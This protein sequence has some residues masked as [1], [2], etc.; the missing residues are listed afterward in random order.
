MKG[1]ALTQQSKTLNSKLHSQILEFCK[2]I[3]GSNKIKAVYACKSYSLGNTNGMAPLE[4]F[5]VI[6]AFQPKLVN[7]VKTFCERNVIFFAVDQWVFE[8]D[9]DKGFLGEAL[10]ASLLLPYIAST[11]E[12]YLFSQE[13]KLKKRLVKELLEN[14]VTD[15]PELSHEIHI[16]PEYFMYEIL[17]S[18][19]RIFPPLIYTL[20]NFDLKNKE[21][22]QAILNGYLKAL[23]ELEKEKIIELS[24]GYVKISRDFIATFR[25]QKIRFTSLFKTAQRTLFVSM[26]KIFPRIISFLSESKDFPLMIQKALA[27]NSGITSQIE[28]PKK[29]LLV[30]TANGLVPLASRVD[31]EAFAKKTLRVDKNAKIVFEEIGGVLNDVYLIKIFVKGEERK[32]VVKSFRDLSSFKW[33]PLTLWTLGTRSFAVSGQSRL[34]REYAINQFLSSKGFAVPKIVHV[35]TAKRLIFMEYVEGENLE[36]IVKRIA[37]SKNIQETAKDLDVI[38]RVGE[39]F[40]EIH[41]LGVALGDTKPENIMVAQNG[42]IY[43]LDFEQASRNG[44]K[45]WDVAEFLYY[46]GHHI[47]PLASPR[48]AE[49]IAKTFIEGYLKAGGN[50]DTIKKAG[51]PK[52][53]KVFSV[54][55]FPHIMFIISNICRKADKLKE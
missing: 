22:R 49:L 1:V 44:D 42:E 29:Y 39:K 9:V 17:W 37:S 8:R 40:A 24:N 54:F 10:S 25:E 13:V 47:P 36:K 3:A 16:K 35:S 51:K 53:T 2:Y 27:E 52:Y 45:I 26:L 55:T 6:Y 20:L 12:D 38:R 14:L 48:I 15:F 7:Y 31:I 28:D 46:A 30:P 50:V 11:G 32:F 5:L 19:T 23:K 41:A 18:R 21:N 4:V 34:E 33:F 43:I